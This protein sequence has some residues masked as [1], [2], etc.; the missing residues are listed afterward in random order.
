[1]KHVWHGCPSQIKFQANYSFCFSV[2]S[3][4]VVPRINMKGMT[5]YAG[6]M[7]QFRVTWGSYENQAW[8]EKR[9][10]VYCSNAVLNHDV[11]CFFWAL[12]SLI[13]CCINQRNHDGCF[14]RTKY[15]FGFFGRVLFV[16]ISFKH[17]KGRCSVPA[18]GL[19]LGRRLFARKE[20]N[21]SPCEVTD[22][23]GM[24]SWQ[25]IFCCCVV[26]FFGDAFVFSF[27]VLSF[28]STLCRVLLKIS[29]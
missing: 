26:C 22:R 10:I 19:R 23:R 24:S 6:C 27:T 16:T 28:I 7:N 20:R 4:A 14:F 9:A 1:M 2:L 5:Q 18:N 17:S 11:G 3:R 8:Q 29:L 13:V 15:F 21:Q 25:P 12:V